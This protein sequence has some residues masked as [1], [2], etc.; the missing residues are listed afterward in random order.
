MKFTLLLFALIYMGCG[1]PIAVP[2]APRGALPTMRCPEHPLPQFSLGA[3]PLP[4][5]QQQA[6]LCSC[7]W[8]QLSEHD[9]R[10]FVPISFGK[11]LQ[12]CTTGAR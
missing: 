6:V 5:K 10:Q 3:N 7:I 2:P 8:S 4:G 9:R 1:R 11:A 12:R